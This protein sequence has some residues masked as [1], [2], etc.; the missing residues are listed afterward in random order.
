VPDLRVDEL[1]GEREHPARAAESSSSS[2]SQPGW[3]AAV[4]TAL[5]R[6]V[7]TAGPR[8][9]WRD[10]RLFTIL[11]VLSLVPRVLA[12]L[13]F[14]PALMTSDSLLYMQESSKWILGEIRPSGYSF[15]LTLLHYVP[16]PLL[17]V[18]TVQHLMG[19]AIAAIVYGLLRYWGL[20]AWGATLAALPTL[21]DTREIAMESYILPDTLFTLCIMLAVAL[22]LTKRTPRLW[23]VTL[24]GLLLAYVTVLR[25]NGIPLA[26]V[27]G[28]YLL[29]RRVG[30]RRLAAGAA[31]FAI[32][33]LGYVMIFHSEYGQYNITNSDGMFLWSG[34]TSFAN[35]AIIKPPADLQ[36]LCPN[37][38]KF[39]AKVAAQ[40]AWS[41]QALLDAPAPAAYLWASDAW[42]RHDAHPGFN[43]YNAKLAMRFAILAIKAQPLD[44]I[45][46]SARDEM[47]VFLGTDRPLSIQSMSFTTKPRLATPLPSYYAHDLYVY[48]HTTTNTHPVQP[49]AYFMFLYQEPV[50]FPGIVF[51]GVVIAGFV[52]LIRKRRQWG[53]GGPAVLPWALAA[54]SL[55]LPALL[56]ES[57]YRYA[58]VAI[59]LA[60][61]AAGL[62]FVRQRQQ[63]SPAAA[64]VTST[65]VAAGVAA[66]GPAATAS[67]TNGSASTEPASTE[68]ASTEPASTASAADA[69]PAPQRPETEPLPAVDRESAAPAPRR[70]DAESRG[71]SADTAPPA[72]RRP[73]AGT[74]DAG[75]TATSAG[76]ATPASRRLNA[77]T[78]ATSAG[79]AAPAPRRPDAGTS[80]TFPDA[81]APAPRRPDTE[82][83]GAS[84]GT[85]PADTAAPTASD[86]AHDAS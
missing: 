74:P 34:T 43:S 72:P 28:I 76:T 78:I 48:A 22:L 13:A 32:P 45:L 30:W 83:H 4:R 65:Q 38:E 66:A 60:C 17:A 58:M 77:E 71:W 5:R 68:P 7:A 62:A 36:P 67:A 40:P 27:A 11:A 18:T 31:A 10:H 53:W 84:A 39:A 16:H 57:L 86:G 54:V 81:T 47:L 25:A 9:L 55:V 51:F 46:T 49:Y 2:P 14:R 75:L 20:P 8:A 1:H 15:F 26:I 23:Q 82:S 59:P 12:A 52:G 42:W 37:R 85:A 69:P 50:Y 80:A 3:D 63:P 64:G 56:K 21:F 73:D 24:A 41:I 44:Y 19:I 70:P 6:A 33:V 61:L 35:C 29:I 79:A